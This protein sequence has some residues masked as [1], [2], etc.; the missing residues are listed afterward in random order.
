MKNEQSIL[1][2]FNVQSKVEFDLTKS[3]ILIGSAPNCDLQIEDSATSHYHALLSLDLSGYGSIQDLGSVNGIQVNNRTVEKSMISPGDTITIGKTIFTV[4]EN[5][6]T[7]VF[8]NTANKIQKIERIEVLQERPENFENL[9]LIDGEYCDINF[10]D[11]NFE[12]IAS[13][14][15]HQAHIETDHYIDIES[16]DQ[17][18]DIVNENNDQSICVTTLVNGVVLDLQYFDINEK[19]YYLSGNN[20]EIY[21]DLFDKKQ[22]VALFKVH[23]NKIQPLECESFTHTQNDTAIVYSRGTYQVIIDIRKAPSSLRSIPFYISEQLFMKK[24][25][26]IFASLFLPALLL[27]MVNFNQEKKKEKKKLSI[28]YK[29]VI[30]KEVTKPVENTSQDA[31]K[32]VKVEG[33]KN[34]KQSPKTEKAAA[35]KKQAAKKTK[36]AKNAPAKS[37]KATKKTK[38]YEFKMKNSVN[39][40]FG[41]VS[42]VKV[43]NRKVADV[44]SGS[45]VGSQVAKSGLSNSKSGTAIGTMG[46]DLKGLGKNSLGTRGLASK[47]GFERARVET[48]TV[49]KG[50]MDPELLR[51][52]L[53]EYLPQF[54]HCYQQELLRN[55]TVKGV[56]D[57]DFQIASHGRANKI[58]VLTN[59]NKFSNKGTGCMAKVLSII[60][61]PKPKGGGVVDVRQPLNFFAEKERS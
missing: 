27:L 37:K 12:P 10:D 52:I 51:K 40:L 36:V 19:I 8:E 54:R 59:D 34:K 60:K 58:N 1:K 53:A 41:S 16:Q 5:I 49:L 24:S 29:K 21:C 44:K 56:I 48:K 18:F 46:S 25:S 47:K 4:E 14:P 55:E 57:L 7:Q 3:Q 26:S 43:D 15:I 30:K 22:K 31:A 61:F 38:A 13:S 6:T 39:S 2:L 17:C 20:K 33:Q 35:S 28:V 11:S 42:D 23:N 45:A 32:V 50:S 9:V